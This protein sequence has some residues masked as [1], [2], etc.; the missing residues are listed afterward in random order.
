MLSIKEEQFNNLNKII[1]DTELELRTNG[2]SGPFIAF[3][4]LNTWD[5]LKTR[6][7]GSP[8]SKKDPFRFSDTTIFY[9]PNLE[10]KII[11]A[12]CNEIIVKPL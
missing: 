5:C 8:I 2:V 12:P 6:G 4:D 10:R 9:T 11:M 7:K 3:V 1:S